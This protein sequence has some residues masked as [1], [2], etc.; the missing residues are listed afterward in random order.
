MFFSWLLLLHWYSY[1]KEN[2]S[3][4][5]KGR[6][7]CYTH[8]NQS[9]TTCLE[10]VFQENSFIFVA[11]SD[12]LPLLPSLK[13]SQVP[14]SGCFWHGAESSTHTVPATI[15]RQ[16]CQGAQ[17]RGVDGE[18][19][20]NHSLPLTSFVIQGMSPFPFVCWAVVIPALPHHCPSKLQEVKKHF[21]IY[22]I[23]SSQILNV[24]NQRAIA[25][26][27]LAWPFTHGLTHRNYR[28]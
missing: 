10:N 23:N 14:S 11:L 28:L 21:I 26:K 8:G 7:Q 15:L 18:R 13:S 5:S 6:I 24:S 25:R 4:P 2:R 12:P 27:H 3:M 20:S 22:A 17:H 19:G 16:P 1:V 9:T